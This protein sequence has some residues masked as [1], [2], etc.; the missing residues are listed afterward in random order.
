MA[1]GPL[2]QSLVAL[3]S[4]RLLISTVLLGSA[5]VIQWR[6]APE[7]QPWPLYVLIGLTFVL[8]ALYATVLQPS[9]GRRWPWDVQLGADALIVAAFVWVTGGVTSYFSSL[10]VL[11][12]ITASLLRHRLSAIRVAVLAALLYVFQVIGQYTDPSFPGWDSWTALPPPLPPPQLAFYTVATNIAGF[13]AVAALSGS[14][15]ERIRRADQDLASA[16]TEIANLQAYNQHIIDSL[17]M[18]LVT[19]EPGGQ[20]LTFNRAAETITGRHAA[21]VIGSVAKEVLQLPAEFAARLDADPMLPG[22][23]RADYRF[24]RPDGRTIE[25]GLSATAFLAQGMRT[26]ELFTFQDVTVLRRLERDARMQQRLAAVGEM[27]AGM[28]HE[29]RNPLASMS[30]SLQ[31]LRHE[32]P[33]SEDQA[34]LMDIV[35]RESARLN[36][37]INHFLAYARPQ[38]F[39]VARIDVR[40]ALNDTAMLLRHSADLDER[41]AIV[42][43]V[44]ETPVWC[45]GDEGQVSQ[46]LW[47]LA[48]NALRAMPDGGQLR[49]SA[50]QDP[51][52]GRAVLEVQDEGEGMTDE[53][54]ERIFQ[55]FHGRF[56]AGSGLGMAIVHRIV[57]DHNGRIRVSS[58]PGAGTTV[59]VDLPLQAVTAPA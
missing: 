29:I 30:G 17:T 43:D 7:V 34:L 5:A 46:I 15:A 47:N 59:A 54:L 53:D 45:D 13:I 40:R 1:K 23:R 10:F 51:D 24:I 28:A 56:A 49:L 44:P 50:F 12:I 9:E 36:Q 14:L 16:S 39:S 21:E 35:Q 37:T 57:T 22:D 6:A 31:L 38:R 26:G 18:G 20:I 8:S 41:H 11:P 32:L 42:V 3:I 19:A 4:L 27:A 25:L 48:T 55:P 58:K 33:L 52:A 2:R